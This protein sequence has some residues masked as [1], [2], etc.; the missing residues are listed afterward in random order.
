MICRNCLLEPTKDKS[1]LRI[2][3]HKVVAQVLQKELQ[4]DS[5]DSN[6]QNEKIS[7]YPCNVLDYFSC[8]YE[9]KDKD[10]KFEH[11]FN[12]DTEYLFEL[13]KI[14]HLVDTSL[15]RAS[16]MT[17]SNES[18]YEIDIESNTIKEIQTL[19]NGKQYVM[20]QHHP[21]EAGLHRIE[22]QSIIPVRNK[23]DI[24]EIL[25]DEDKLDK[26]LKQGLSKEDYQKWSNNI[27]NHFGKIGAK[28][29]FD[30]RFKY[31]VYENL[32]KHRCK[33]CNQSGN[34]H[35]VKGDEWY[36]KKHVKSKV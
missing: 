35:L 36:C 3:I 6:E 27:L 32:A 23:E 13:E 24:L 17:K 28:L 30:Y 4:I 11:D 7:V 20:M 25:Q 8:P 22:E 16:T 29:K 10:K 18:I 15:L 2:G 1:G 34:I 12:S 33:R 21:I 9:N 14:T 19:Y 26:I 31:D 5:D